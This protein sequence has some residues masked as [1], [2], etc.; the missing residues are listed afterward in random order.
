MVKKLIDIMTLLEIAVPP[1][2]NCHHMITCAKFGSD[3]TGWEDRLLVQINKDGVF[4]SLFWDE[5]DFALPVAEL[6]ALMVQMLNEPLAEDF[7]VSEVAGSPGA[8][9]IDGKS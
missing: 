8:V 7:Q 3:E 9:P 4:F 6:V 2:A 5:E 1:P